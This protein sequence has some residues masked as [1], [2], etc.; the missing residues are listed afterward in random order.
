MKQLTPNI[1]NKLIERIKIH[2]TNKKHSYNNIKV[3]IPFT[4][5]GLFNIPTEQQLIDTTERVKQK[6]A[7]KSA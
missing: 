1:V 7:V 2:S 3:D 4:T 6:S 5:V